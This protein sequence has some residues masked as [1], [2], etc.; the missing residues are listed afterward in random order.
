MRTIPMQPGSCPTKAREDQ[1]L[2]QL[3]IPVKH[4]DGLFFFFTPQDRE[5]AEGNSNRPTEN[6][7]HKPV[8]ESGEGQ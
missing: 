3:F 1:S 5:M 8:G 7:F 6:G 4:V 2:N